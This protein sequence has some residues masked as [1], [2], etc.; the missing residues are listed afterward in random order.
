MEQTLEFAFIFSAVHI[1]QLNCMT[2]MQTVDCM[3][4]VSSNWN[5]DLAT[6]AKRKF[7]VWLQDV[8]I[9]FYERILEINP[10]GIYI[11]SF[12]VDLSLHNTHLD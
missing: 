1:T 10:K 7:P 5:C 8:C 4:V 11:V 3:V 2:Y 6:A 12:I 9:V